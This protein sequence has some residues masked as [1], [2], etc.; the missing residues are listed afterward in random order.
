MSNRSRFHG[1]DN[2][3]NGNGRM[4]AP[5]YGTDNRLLIPSAQPPPQQAVPL[6]Q[7]VPMLLQQGAQ[8]RYSVGLS[9]EGDTAVIVLGIAVGPIQVPMG[10]TPD[11]AR[12]LAAMLTDAAEKIDTPAVL[13][14]P[15][16]DPEPE[17]A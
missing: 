11:M 1:I 12:S 10:L 9:T 5:P 3:P 14:H 6:D 17:T 4:P 15:V 16:P 7:V 8:I 2:G 13:A